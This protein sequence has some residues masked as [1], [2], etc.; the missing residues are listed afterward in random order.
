MTKTTKTKI[1]PFIKAQC[2]KGQCEI[3]EARLNRCTIPVLAYNLYRL[4]ELEGR[5]I[6]ADHGDQE[7]HE[8]GESAPAPVNV[9][10]NDLFQ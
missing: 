1:C 6:E 9:A 3:Y 7:A 8:I 10:I 4:S 2:P 5:R